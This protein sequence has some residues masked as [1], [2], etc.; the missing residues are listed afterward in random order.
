M[1][2]YL[3]NKHTLIFKDFKFKCCIGANGLS[4]KKKEGDKTTPI[5]IFKLGNLY[6]RPDKISKIRTLLKKKKN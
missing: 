5:G 6:Y 2:I 1:I 3:K 4:K